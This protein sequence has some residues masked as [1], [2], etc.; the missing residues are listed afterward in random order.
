MNYAKHQTITLAALLSLLLSACGASP[1]QGSAASLPETASA[2]SSAP[3]GMQLL[4][5]DS[6]G[7]PLKSIAALQLREDQAGS[8]S[9]RLENASGG[10]S[11]YLELQHAAS[12]GAASV[13]LAPALQQRA[14]LIS[15][16]LDNERLQIGIT[17]IGEGQNLPV[18]TQ[19]LSIGFSGTDV[20]LR[21]ISAVAISP[22]EDIFFIEPDYNTM[23]WTYYCNGDYD[24]NGI[25][26]ISD[27][28]PIGQHF[29]KDQQA[30]S[31]LQARVADGD[32]N[33][34]VNISDIT[35][36]GVNFG[37]SIESFLIL[38]SGSSG[39]PFVPVAGAVIPYDSA[40]IPAQG[41]PRT[42][43]YTLI[44]PPYGNYFVVTPFDGELAGTNYGTPGRYLPENIPPQALA[45]HDGAPQQLPGSLISFDASDSYDDDGEIVSFEWDPENSGQWTSTQLVPLFSYTY[46]G[47]G[48]FQPQLRVTDNEGQQSVFAMSTITVSLGQSVTRSPYGGPG[49][50]AP[51][52]AVQLPDGRPALSY[53][54]P[55][56][57]IF[58][59]PYIV[60]ATS[61]AAAAWEQPQM[62]LISPT[63]CEEF[64]LTTAGIDL[65]AYFQHGEKLC[66]EEFLDNGSGDIDVVNLVDDDPQVIRGYQISSFSLFDTPAVA[67]LS[68]AADGSG[69]L[70]F[71]NGWLEFAA[72][73]VDPLNCAS[74]CAQQLDSGPAVAYVRVIDGNS[75][76]L[77]FRRAT[78]INGGSWD[79]A[80]V[81]V[82][83]K[84][85]QTSGHSL[86]RAGNRL[87]IV[88]FSSTDQSLYSISSTD[89]AG[90]AWGSPRLIESQCDTGSRYTLR[91]IKGL[92]CVLYSSA[93]ELKYAIA[94]NAQA[95]SWNQAV[96][97]ASSPTGFGATDMLEIDGKPLIFCIDDED[98]MLKAIS[99]E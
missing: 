38:G 35:P 54:Q 85:A 73:L 59:V 92:P 1:Q 71:T 51:I 25:V 95:S 23:H 96:S 86:I 65:F 27:I 47:L 57:N 61:P 58:N 9:L 39:G 41:G 19:L 67:Y 55:Y 79:P 18:M 12:P 87:V 42:W 17:M 97:L 31:W 74:P 70:L 4:Q 46:T 44:D 88:Y 89:S 83:G 66:I 98:G 76:N 52:S 36:I 3:A 64:S 81:L 16:N 62:A 14:L 94:R 45:F 90:T 15:R 82:S 77:T 91:L 43:S 63:P 21:E 53:I 72:Q 2:Q 80:Q 48:S 10:H 75:S 99:F 40:P 24:Q 37:T 22:V 34:V 11:L 29:G 93:T 8:F 60:R 28:T 68:D 49:A 30:A 13:E 6:L 5:L 78:D 7:Q 56:Q 32:K 33:R 84:G 20:P 50:A 26:N 69:P